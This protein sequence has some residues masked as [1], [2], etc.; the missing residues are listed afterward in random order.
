M[1]LQQHLGADTIIKTA[2]TA[3]IKGKI[4]DDGY[5]TLGNSGLSMIDMARGFSTIANQGKKPTLHIVASV[6][7]ASTA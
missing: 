6:K 3:G 4:T 7:S 5:V 1:D 2:H